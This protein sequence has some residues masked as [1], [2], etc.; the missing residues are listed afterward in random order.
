MPFQ[1]AMKSVISL[2]LNFDQVEMREFFQEPRTTFELV[3]SQVPTVK[4]DMS[5]NY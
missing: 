1:S 2:Q 5:Y 3:L 4:P